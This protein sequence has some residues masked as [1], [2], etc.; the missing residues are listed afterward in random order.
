MLA[1][2]PVHLGKL[3]ESALVGRVAYM[4]VVFDEDASGSS[5]VSACVSG[6]EVELLVS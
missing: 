2:P 1:L 4:S 5:E 6:V 3:S